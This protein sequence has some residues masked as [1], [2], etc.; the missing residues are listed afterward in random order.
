MMTLEDVLG[1]IKSLSVKADNYY[2]GT[3]D[4]KKDK[5]FGVYSLKDRPGYT[6]AIGGAENKKIGQKGISIL[7]HWNSST[8]QTEN[9]ALQLFHELETSRNIVSG[10]KKVNYL[11]LLYDEPIDVGHDE[12]GVCERVIEFVIF[13]ERS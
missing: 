9:V 12:N 2:C 5:A 11:K 7:V 6:A 4:K 8:R 10:G 13:Y 1:F 3:L